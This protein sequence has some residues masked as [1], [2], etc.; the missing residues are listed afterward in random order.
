VGPVLPSVERPDRVQ[1]GPNTVEQ[2][3]GTLGFNPY[4]SGPVSIRLRSEAFGC[5]SGDHADAP[6]G[7][8]QPPQILEA[9][10]LIFYP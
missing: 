2:D 10:F 5:V 7:R 4:G 6:D 9:T 8:R 1:E 3:T